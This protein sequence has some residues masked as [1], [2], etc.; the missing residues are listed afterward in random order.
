M[1]YRADAER[2]ND[3]LRRARPVIALA[4][5]AFAIGVIVGAG[6]GPSARDRLA[7]SF[8]GAWAKRDYARMYLDLDVGSRR[9]ISAG[10]FAEGYQR[11][12]RTATATRLS[13]A[14]QPRDLGRGLVRV[15]VRVRTRLFGTLALPFDVT[16]STLSGEPRIAWSPSLAF[17]GLHR[18][19]TLSRQLT[20]PPRARLLARDGSVLA[21]GSPSTPGQRSSPLGNVAHAVL[22]ALGAAPAA[23]RG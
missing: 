18:G 16:V 7:A 21:E 8:V 1:F 19:E 3:R 4:A 12:L 14:G 10:A 23:R 13:V 17:P 2:P 6:H 5:V 11:A 20:L 15:P 22:G 9:A